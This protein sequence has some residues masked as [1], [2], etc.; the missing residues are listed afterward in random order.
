[1]QKISFAQGLILAVFALTVLACSAA[2]KPGTP[3]PKEES[4]TPET[5]ITATAGIEISSPT[6]TVTVPMPTQTPSFTPTKDFANPP[7]TLLVECECSVMD[8]AWS[9]DG[10][11]LV[12]SETYM[13]E[14]PALTVWDTTTKELV[15]N[16]PQP[17]SPIGGRSVDWKTNSISNTSTIVTGGWTDPYDHPEA[18]GIWDGT[19]GEL[20]ESYEID[21]VAVYSMK[22]SPDGSLLAAGLL[23]G[24]DARIGIRVSDLDTGELRFT[25]PASQETYALVDFVEDVAWSPDGDQIALAGERGKVL[26]WS[27]G[28]A[29][30]VQILT[31]PSPP[32]EHVDWSPDGSKLVSTGVGYIF[33]WDAE[34]HSLLHSTQVSGWIQDADFSPD[35]TKLVIA[36]DTDVIHVFDPATGQH[37]LS[38][39]RG[40]VAAWSPDGVSLAMADYDGKV[41]IWDLTPQ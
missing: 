26:I 23:C 9:P 13:Y 21:D 1:M 3:I 16:L 6:P 29:Q 17:A 33:I 37:L 15:Y 39:R 35:G 20:L 7:S 4:E 2:N 34:T 32:A 31:Q 18:I 40:H 25:F 36:S 30:S 24:G 12:I 19:T 27:L 10:S 28:T 38:F 11:Q 5:D 41:V 22:L 14:P 8:L